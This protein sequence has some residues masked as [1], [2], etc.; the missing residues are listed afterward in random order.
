MKKI[1]LAMALAFALTGAM[2]VATVIWHID[3]AS[4]DS[5]DQSPS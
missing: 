5:E 4:A 1:F 2:V 3:E